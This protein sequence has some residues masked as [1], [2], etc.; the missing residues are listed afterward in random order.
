[1]ALP[2]CHAQSLSYSGWAGLFKYDGVTKHF[3]YNLQS[4]LL[5][6][7]SPISVILWRV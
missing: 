7:F 6:Y 4:F 1:M 3:C 5:M 2:P